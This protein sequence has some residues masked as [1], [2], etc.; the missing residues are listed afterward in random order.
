MEERRSLTTRE[1]LLVTGKYF[2]LV[3]ISSRFYSFLCREN[4]AGDEEYRPVSTFM[5][6]PYSFVAGGEKTFM[7]YK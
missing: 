4:V 5:I 7:I 1:E 3:H 2:R 6:F